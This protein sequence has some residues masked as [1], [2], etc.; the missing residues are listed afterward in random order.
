[1]TLDELDEAL[2]DPVVDHPSLAARLGVDADELQRAAEVRKV[3]LA[4]R[5]PG[6]NV[7]DLDL[8]Y[9]TAAGLGASHLTAYIRVTEQLAA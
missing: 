2:A 1:M 3:L 6:G 9:L 8:N 5:P 4:G 7:P